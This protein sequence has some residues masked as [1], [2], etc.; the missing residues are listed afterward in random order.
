MHA[1]SYSVPGDPDVLQWTEQPVP[2]YAPDEVLIRV[3]AAGLNR[4]D[5][6]QRQGKYPPPDGSS[7]V[8]GLEVAG[9][10]VASGREVKR[11]RPGD[12]VCALLSGG[13]YA[14]YAAVPEG[15]C[16]LIPAGL[17]SMDAAALPEG[18][19]TVWANIFEIGSLQPGQTVL[20]H[21]GASGIG[22]TAIQ[23]VKAFGARIFVTARDEEKCEACRKLGADLAVNYR[24]ED[25]IAAVEQATEK[26]GVDIVLDMVGG[27]YVMRNLMALAPGGRHISIAVQGG[28]TAPIDLWMI[29][30]KQLA[31]T[32]STLRHRPAPEKARLMRA[33]EEK[34]WPWIK[35]NK[36]KPLIYKFFSIKEAAAAHKLMESGE[37]IGKI[38]LEVPPAK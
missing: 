25:F 2:E 14:E 35:N 31:L 13:G 27:D 37:H 11:W 5:I 26:R 9:E 4:A 10:I 18:V 38:V 22:T 3:A 17:S 24:R 6:L 32:G 7:P 19:A 29:M 1:I 34:V 21:G 8:L 15:Q 30:R 28:K 12:K 23:M 36:L 20:V 33:V 16:L